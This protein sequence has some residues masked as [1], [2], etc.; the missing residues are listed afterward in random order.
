M[1]APDAHQMLEVVAVVLHCPAK[2]GILV[3]GRPLPTY[4]ESTSC[5]DVARPLPCLSVHLRLDAE[6]REEDVQRKRLA[7]FADEIP[8]RL[9][10]HTRD[11]VRDECID[12]LAP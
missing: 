9:G 8:L 3:R 7:D 4:G 5:L 2:I 11:G 1:F 10:A 12:F 6:H